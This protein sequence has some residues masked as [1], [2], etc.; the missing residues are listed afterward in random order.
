MIA[1]MDTSALPEW[2]RLQVLRAEADYAS[3]K[4]DVRVAYALWCFVGVFGGHPFYLRDT[5]RSLIMCFTLGGPARPFVMCSPRGGLGV[6]PL[7]VV[8]FTAGRV[9]A[10]TR[11]RRAA[12]MS[13]LGIIDGTPT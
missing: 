3:V 12:V 2:Q 6:G 7:L 13:R 1:A 4:K 10:A 9:K 11:P 5:A 8:F